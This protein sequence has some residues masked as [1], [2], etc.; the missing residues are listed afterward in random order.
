MAWRAAAAVPMGTAPGR[1]GRRR[2]AA[3]TL[4]GF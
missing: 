3:A 2:A 1:P 4:R